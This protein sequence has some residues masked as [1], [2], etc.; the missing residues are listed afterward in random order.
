MKDFDDM[1]K[2]EQE[3]WRQEEYKQLVIARLKTMP[4]H[5]RISIG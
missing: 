3:E 2:E 5:L 1:T 4:S